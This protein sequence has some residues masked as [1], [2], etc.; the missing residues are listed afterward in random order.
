[1]TANRSKL[2]PQ[3]HIERIY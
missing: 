3:L 2:L 1:M